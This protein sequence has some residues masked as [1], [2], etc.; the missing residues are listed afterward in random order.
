M[1]PALQSYIVVPTM[2]RSFSISKFFNHRT[3][4]TAIASMPREKLQRE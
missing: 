1:S 4:D 2:H 3:A